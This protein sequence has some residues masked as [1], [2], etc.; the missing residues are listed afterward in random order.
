MIFAGS[1]TLLGFVSLP[2]TFAPVLL[3]RKAKRLRMANPEKNKEIYAESER[4]SWAPSAVLE[5]TIF[6]P[7]KMLF[8]EPILLLAT[9]YLSV[10]YGVIYASASN[11]PSKIVVF[12]VRFLTL[13]SCL[14][15]FQALPVIFIRTRHF[16]VSNDGLV[17]I[18]IGIGS[19]FATVVNL[20]F[21]RPYPRL[22][23]QWHG[24]PPAE[25]RLYSAMVGGPVLVVGILWLGWSGNYESV[26]W[27]VPGLST[28]LIGLAI[29]LVFIS[30]IVRLIF[31]PNCPF[32]SRG[33]T[34]MWCAG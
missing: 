2:E 19:V 14:A 16:S 3:A 10:A 34:R 12:E 24:F 27:W 7:F 26:P 29:T 32:F 20:W 6:R 31:F 4:V 1:C 30:F 17:F 18:G 25:E 23:K 9:V 8:V 33:L 15:V 11:Y 13:D 22:L 28:I 21:L 5:R